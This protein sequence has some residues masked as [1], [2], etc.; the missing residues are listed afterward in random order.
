LSQ[1]KLDVPESEHQLTFKDGVHKIAQT[2]LDEIYPD[3]KRDFTNIRALEIIGNA[4]IGNAEWVNI[5][6]LW[7]RVK[8][9]HALES[10]AI[11]DIKASTTFD[12][13]QSILALYLIAILAI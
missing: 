11:I 7:A 8:Q 9:I 3:R 6:A 4:N 10:Q 12:Q 13:K 1:I 2:K 5:K